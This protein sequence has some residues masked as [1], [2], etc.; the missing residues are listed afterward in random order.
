MDFGDAFKMLKDGHVV[1]RKAWPDRTRISFH[2]SKDRNT[3]MRPFLLLM[4][5][6]WLDANSHLSASPY[7]CEER[8]PWLPNHA[9]IIANDWEMIDPPRWSKPDGA[10]LFLGHTSSGIDAWYG[11]HFDTDGGKGM[12]NGVFL[13]DGRQGAEFY[14]DHVTA[15][16]WS[17][18]DAARRRFKHVQALQAALV[19]D[20]RARV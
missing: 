5:T 16:E 6:P 2:Q 11:T 19:I 14:P 8:L 18:V 15:G 4:S 1:R 13:H 9:D 17:S 3:Q 10:T 12:A 20:T 7:L